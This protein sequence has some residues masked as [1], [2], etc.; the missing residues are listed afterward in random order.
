[1]SE[2]KKY[3]LNPVHATC[4][5]KSNN[6]N[7]SSLALPQWGI[8]ELSDQTL[9]YKVA[10]LSSL[11]QRNLNKIL[12]YSKDNRESACLTHPFFVNGNLEDRIKDVRGG[13]VGHSGAPHAAQPRLH[14]G[15]HFER[16]SRVEEADGT[17]SQ[18]LLHPGRE[19]EGEEEI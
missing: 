3:Q 10:E 17:H 11:K 16:Q 2:K 12:G 15:T 13:G 5:K 14:D 6:N 19:G 9:N 4:V 7:S 8:P 18:G 1:M